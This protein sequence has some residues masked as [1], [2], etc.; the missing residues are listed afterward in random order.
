MDRPAVDAVLLAGGASRRYGRPKAEAAWRGRTLAEHVLDALPDRTGRTVLVLRAEGDPV[1]VA[2]DALTHDPP[3]SPA[4]PLHGVIAGLRACAAPL[5]WV[6]ACDLPGLGTPLLEM[7]AAA[8]RP[9]DAAV[10]P[11][12]NG[13]QQP[14]CAL[15]EVAAA[16]AL[17]AAARDGVRSVRGALETIAPR[18]L[19]ED[20][21]RAADPLGLSFHNVNSPADLESLDRILAGATQNPE[22]NP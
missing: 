18:F 14:L 2:T 13:R 3:G 5:A 1:P 9:G 10:V 6:L 21:V 15:Y 11:V 20:E 8:H 16:D 12:W 22:R 7:L 17:E 4:G 19:A